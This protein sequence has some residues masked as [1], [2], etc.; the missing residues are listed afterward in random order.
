MRT[1]EARLPR[2]ELPAWNRTI[3]Y[4]TSRLAVGILMR[5]VFR[6]RIDGRE[7]LPAGP[8]VLCFNHLSW[9]DPFLL[10]ATL[11]LRPRLYL[12][13]PREDDLRHGPRNRL[14]YW[15]G[16]PVPFKSGKND[17]LETTRRVQAVFDVGGVLAIAGEGRIH[18]GERVLL[19][20]QDG[21]AYFALRAGVPVVPVALNGLSW[22]GFRR[23]LR[24]RIGAPITTS[25]RPT[26]RA[27]AEL[28]EQTSVALL[29]L[30]ADASDPLPPG[31]F[32]RWLTE[33]FNEWPEGSRAAAEAAAA[34]PRTTM[35]METSP[36]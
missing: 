3:R 23:Q 5:L 16:T 8:A 25:G 35:P 26:S 17:L 14:M 29:G 20:L 32:G 34:A 12:F 22:L 15:T 24:V 33:Y 36:P 21:A 11:P 31:R 6:L 28:T 13:G 4:W 1:A 30:L 18:V 7:H 9:M 19:P 27:I 2:S 10:F